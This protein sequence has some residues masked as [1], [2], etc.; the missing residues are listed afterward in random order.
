[1]KRRFPLHAVLRVRKAREEAARA[2]A[3]RASGAFTNATDH[4]ARR[5]ASLLERT[6]PTNAP[7][8]AFLGAVSATRSMATEVAGLHELARLRQEE[9][10][11]AQQDWVVTEQES[12]AVERLAE[13]HQV[14]IQHELQRAEQR[15]MDELAQRPRHVVD[16]ALASDEE[17]P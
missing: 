17:Q 15:E 10:V 3:A 7:I 9:L 2:E 6:L 14:T 5:E 11:A 1:M 4:A 16:W 13:R 8:A 12:S